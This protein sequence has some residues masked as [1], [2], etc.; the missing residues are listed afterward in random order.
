MRETLNA[1]AD[2]LL[3]NARDPE[4]IRVAGLA[5]NQLWDIRTSRSDNQSKVGN[6]YF[7]E[8][9]RV[10]KGLDAAFLNYDGGQTG[11]LHLGNIHP[12]AINPDLSA[13]E[14][15]RQIEVRQESDD[16]TDLPAG[17][18]I[19]DYMYP[20]RKVLVQVLRDPV[21]NKGATLTTFISLAGAFIVLMPSLDRIGISRRIEEEEERE[22]LRCDLSDIVADSTLPVIA[23]TAAEGEPK[24]VLRAD[25]RRLDRRWQSLLLKAE[26]AKKPSLVLEE[27]SP[28]LRAVR[29]LFQ[30]GLK[31]IVVDDVELH[32]EIKVFLEE[33]GASGARVDLKLHAEPNPVFESYNVEEQYQRLFRPKVPLGKGA[34]LV[35]QQTEALVAIDVNSGRIDAS[36]LEDT[37][38]ETNLLAA[39]EISRQ[40]KLRDL[41]GIVVVDFIDMRR[42]EHR[43]KIESVLREELMRD[44]ARMKC[45][46][47]GSF[48][49]MS[50]TRRRNDNGPFKTLSGMCKSCQGAGSMGQIEAAKLRVVRR[51]RTLAKKSK[52]SIRGHSA[53]IE[54]LKRSPTIWSDLGHD[55]AFEED[56]KIPIGEPIIQVLP[57]A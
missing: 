51:I 48:G 30:G 16:D 39:R 41:G 47:I 18:K 37:A 55:I 3:V 1:F 7:A 24:K 19:T 40:V 34:S 21:K 28:A 17:E 15:M 20:G 33:K 27:E 36:N 50:F 26:S 2:T 12:A 6:V 56:S 9:T 35:I 5:N 49:L 38:F 31:R 43:R 8:V 53:L 44:R 52:L 14:L 13:I 10:E 25:F 22:R 29:E 4:E 45:G 46:R 11:F 23:R 54:G 32:K 42:A 57:L